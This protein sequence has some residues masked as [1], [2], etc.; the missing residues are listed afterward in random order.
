MLIRHVYFVNCCCHS[1]ALNTASC[2]SISG[3]FSWPT[4]FLVQHPTTC[5]WSMLSMILQ[6]NSSTSVYLLFSS[7]QVNFFI[8]IFSRWRALNGHSLQMRWWENEFGIILIVHHWMVAHSW[9]CLFCP[10][11]MQIN[12]TKL[13]LNYI[14]DM[15]SR[16][17][18]TGP[19]VW[20]ESRYLFS[21]I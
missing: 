20:L 3:C 11:M 13:L 14:Y 5:K 19:A 6:F 1:T 17:T 7:F 4:I 9:S 15:I 16:T 12:C 18:L 10:R 21:L 2:T 8:I